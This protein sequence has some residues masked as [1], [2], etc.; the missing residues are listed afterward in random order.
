MQWHLIPHTVITGKIKRFPVMLSC[1]YHQQGLVI[2]IK[3]TLPHAERPAS[4]HF[5]HPR[6][7]LLL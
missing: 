2:T 5:G 1:G 3:L 7:S 6:A 4:G